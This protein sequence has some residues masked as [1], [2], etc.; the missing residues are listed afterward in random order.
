MEGRVLFHSM[1]EAVVYRLVGLGAAASEAQ[2]DQ[3]AVALE[4][5]VEALEGLGALEVAALAV[6]EDSLVGYQE[7]DVML[8][9]LGEILEDPLHLHLPNHRVERQ[10]RPTT[11]APRATPPWKPL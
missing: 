7:M 6:Q 9:A 5:Q 10:A 11:T 4:V 2:V 3:G 8:E 1:V